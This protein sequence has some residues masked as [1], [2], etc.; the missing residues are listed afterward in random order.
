MAHSRIIGNV[1][2]LID[3]NDKL[4]DNN[5]VVINYEYYHGND[6]TID[7]RSISV[8]GAYPTLI[9]NIGQE[10]LFEQAKRDISNIE[11]EDVNFLTKTVNVI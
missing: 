2:G 8:Y 11:G 1:S 3:D 6:G 9:R 5:P 10:R 4:S 7:I